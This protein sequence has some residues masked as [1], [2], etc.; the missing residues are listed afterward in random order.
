[1]TGCCSFTNRA[2]LKH[3]TNK[4]PRC[5]SAEG[6]KAVRGRAAL[7]VDR[8]PRVMKSQ[9]SVYA[10]PGAAGL[11]FMRKHSKLGTA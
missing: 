4:P 3:S 1:M 7:P 10:D 9:R 6:N 8:R 5:L 11:V 2:E